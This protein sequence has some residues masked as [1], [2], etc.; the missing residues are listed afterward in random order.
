MRI[1]LGVFLVK[2]QILVKK[3]FGLG[4]VVVLGGEKT[5]WRNKRKIRFCIEVKINKKT[6]CKH[7]FQEVKL[8][9]WKS[10][11][12]TWV[13]EI[14]NWFHGFETHMVVPYIEILEKYSNCVYRQLGCSSKTSISENDRLKN[15]WCDWFAEENPFIFI[16]LHR[17]LWMIEK[18]WNYVKLVISKKQTIPLFK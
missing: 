13:F 7:F 3:H 12:C 2:S 17:F 11:S 8:G 9:A 15:C 18:T 10:I 5:T 1:S 14:I 4:N 6:N 16:E